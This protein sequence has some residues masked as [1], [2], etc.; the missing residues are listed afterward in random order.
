L[1]SIRNPR[2]R[3]F[4]AAVG[5]LVVLSS[6]AARAEPEAHESADAIFHGQI[7]PLTL[8][9]DRLAPAG[10]RLGFKLLKTDGV[11]PASLSELTFELDPRIAIDFQGTPLCPRSVLRDATIARATE[12]CAGALVGSGSATYRATFPGQGEFSIPAALVAFNGRHEGRP[13]ILVYRELSGK[14]VDPHHVY[15]FELERKGNRS[16]GIS[17]SAEAPRG[18]FT[19]YGW[20]SSFNLSLERHYSRNGRN[21]S[22]VSASCPLPAETQV[23]GLPIARARYLLEDGSEDSGLLYGGCR[24]GRTRSN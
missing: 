1:N 13:A 2:L 12:L 21:H 22:Y 14:I 15:V 10:L 6:A 18:L 9:R 11:A 19:G 24:A 20:T 4:A 23:G 5:A 7:S 8:P 16:R 17:L 3:R